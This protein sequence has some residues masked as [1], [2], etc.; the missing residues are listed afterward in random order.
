MVYNKKASDKFAAANP[1]YNKNYARMFYKKRYNS[2]Q[3]F[4]D[5]ERL[6]K[7]LDYHKK[8][9]IEKAALFIHEENVLEKLQADFVEA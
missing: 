6:R 3:Q 4:R 8:K 9:D 2:S 5:K 1:D 7:R